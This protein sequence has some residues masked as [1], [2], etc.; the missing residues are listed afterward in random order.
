MMTPSIDTPSP[1]FEAGPVPELPI[2]GF[3]QVT[4]YVGNAKQSACFY[5]KIMGFDIIAYQGPETGCRDT[6]SYLLQQNRIRL[7]LTAAMT[8]DHP[9]ARHVAIHGDGIKD[10]AF[11]VADIQ[12][13]YKTA[14]QRGAVSVMPPV[15]LSDAQGHI[16]KATIATYGDTTHTFICRDAYTGDLEPGFIPHHLPTVSTGL[17]QIDHVVGNVE[18]HRLEDWVR[19]YEQVFGFYVLRHYDETDIST[20][21]SALVSKVMANQSGTV[22]MPINEPAAGLRKSQIEEYLD[23][24]GS[25]GVQH[26]ALSTQDIIST[27][28]SLRQAGLGLMNVPVTYYE[29]LRHRIASI[30]EPMDQLQ[31]LGIL[32]D[33]D[34]GGYLLQIFTHPVQDRPTFFFEIIQRCEGAP[35]FG[36]GNFKA[37]FEAIER[38]QALRGN[39]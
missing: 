18:A 10:I 11:R 39:M 20:Q 30:V 28:R 6:C 34:E 14:I 15:I 35:G 21:Y 13:V 7:V 26:L 31:D 37:L 1:A 5:N 36:K 33:R 17:H 29:D 27:V 12:S 4:F 25:A 8:S 32:V 3:D 2:L 22:K 38:D 24:Y 19:F 23:F 9:V 16:E